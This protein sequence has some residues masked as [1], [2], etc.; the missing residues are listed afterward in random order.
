MSWAMWN[1]GT[2]MTRE[3]ARRGMEP[4]T[5]DRVSMSD[6]LAYIRGRRVEGWPGPGGGIPGNARAGRNLFVAKGC[7]SCHAIHGAGGRIGPAL[8]DPEQYFSVTEIAANMWNHGPAMARKVEEM[9]IQ[10]PQISEQQM[11]DLI[12]Y[13]YFSCYSDSPGDREKGRELYTAKHCNRCH[14]SKDKTLD[15][16]PDLSTSEAVQSPPH[17]ISAMWNHAG[18]MEESMR[19]RKI[20]WPEFQGDEMRDL[21]TYLTSLR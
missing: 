14:D 19:R 17:L 13:L 21:L 11:A 8:S 12:A 3:M 16:A 10:R 2:G 18:A 4:P 20:P 9:K 5:F 15:E 1:H 7:Q 6:L